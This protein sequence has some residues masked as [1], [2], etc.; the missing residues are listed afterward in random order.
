MAY[1]T[2]KLGKDYTA[3]TPGFLIIRLIAG[4]A[5]DTTRLVVIECTVDDEVVASAS[6]ADNYVENVISSATQTI[7]VPVGRG[8]T[9]RADR[10]YG[11]GK[12]EMRWTTF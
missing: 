3:R 10:T 11:D 4:N 7:T 9:Y 8:S 2:K 1:T 12:V 5:T 6:A